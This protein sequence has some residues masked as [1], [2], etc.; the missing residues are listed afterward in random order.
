VTRL[1]L[2]S[3]G[4]FAEAERWVRDFLGQVH[5]LLFVPYALHD[6]AGYTAHVRAL[7]ASWGLEVEGLEAADDPVAAVQRAQALFVGGGNTFR[8]LVRLR[9]AGLLAPIR[10]R[11]RAGMPYLGSSAGSN[12]A[13]PTIMTTNDM[14]IVHPPSFEALG[15][16]PFQINPHY[17]D[18]DPTSPSQGETREVRIRE[19][20]EMN[21]LPVI[22]LREGSLLIREDGVLRLEGVVG[23]RLFRRGQEPVEVAPGSRLDDLLAS[24]AGA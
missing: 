12:V 10:D 9:E 15:L 2:H 23:A 4:R 19:Y 8:L 20:H 11:V 14:P 18:P 16:V 6:Q 17:L 5:R 1:L 13:C 21:A 22:G 24:D 3:G 7:A